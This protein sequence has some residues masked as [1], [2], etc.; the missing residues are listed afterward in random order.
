MFF[1][2]RRKKSD[3]PSPDEAQSASS[4]PPVVPPAPVSSFQSADPHEPEIP[5]L[6]GDYA[7][8]VFLWVT[9]RSS[10][11]TPSFSYPGYLLY[12]CGIRNAAQYLQ[13]LFEEGCYAEASSVDRLAALKVT[14]LKPLLLELELP[15]SGKK[16][17]L[18]QRI[19]DHSDDAFILK[20]CPDPMY[21]LSEK[22]RT[23]LEEHDDYVKLH[24]HKSRWGVSWQE[25]DSRKR[26]GQSF[27]DVMWGIFNER[28]LKEQFNFGRNAYLNM[29]QL[30]VEEGR[31]SEA[32]EMLLRVLYIDLSGADCVQKRE[33]FSKKEL[34][35]DFSISITLAPG[36]NQSI[37]EYQDV[38]TDE[39][40]NRL[41]EWKL[42]MNI[43]SKKLFTSIVHS[44]LDGSFDE[45]SVRQKLKRAYNNA[46][47]AM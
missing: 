30:L 39:I 18:I 22:G 9:S 34:K 16:D 46:I 41:Y 20:H 25:Y 32:V 6:Q 13:S 4:Q 42:P 27:H 40:I 8:T 1:S 37:S 19:L 3:T 15:V 5:P 14:E 17:A 24:T 12:E 36:I 23:F 29:Y 2:K 45:E 31:R 21:T 26:P 47:D 35:D 11:I 38:Y 44:A 10:V 33:F 7:K 28:V 43:C